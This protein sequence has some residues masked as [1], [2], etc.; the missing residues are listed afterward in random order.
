MK[1]HALKIVCISALLAAT[2]ILLSASL[3]QVPSGTWAAVGSMNSARAGASTV[4]LQDGRILITGGSD[5]NGPSSAAEFFGANGSFSAAASMNV[6]RSGHISVV[7]QD[8][9]VLVA[10]GTTSGGGVTNSAEMFD[11]TANSWTNVTGGMMEARSGETATLLSDGRVLIAGGSGSGASISMTAELFDT[12]SQSF[13][14]AGVLSSA[15]FNHAAALLLDGRVLIVG[16]SDGSKALATSDIFD[17]VASTI[18][19]GPKLATARQALSA[20]TL[21]DGRVLIA[22]GNNVVVNPD[23][24]SS[25]V[26]L[27]SAEILDAGATAFSNAASALV[28]ARSGQQAFLLPHNNSVLIVG[29][30]SNGTT[31]A[32]AE[33][34]IP[35][36]N[37]QAGIFQ[38]TGSMATPRSGAT[39]AALQQDGLLLVAGGKDAGGTPLSSSELYGF[40]TVK[41]DAADYPPGTTVNITGSGW[42]P[43]EAVTLTL[44]E[45]PLIDT[46]G[47][48]TVT[49]DANGN[50]SDSSFVTDAHDLNVKF[51]LTAV[52]LVSQ[53]QTIFTDATHIGSITVGAQTGSLTYGSASSATYTVTVTGSG[54][55][56]VTATL[57]IT[58]LPAGA[59][60]TFSPASVTVN[61]SS[62][63]STLTITT[64]TSAQAAATTF[65]VTNTDNSVTGTGTLTIGKRPITVTA[66]TNSKQYDG[67]TAAAATPTI[68]SGTPAAGDTA[69]FTEAYST[70][71]V[72]TGNKTLI[73]S[74]SVNDGHGGV[75]YTVIFVNNT[76]GTIS[77][78]PLTVTAT[79]NSKTYDGTT[80]AA[81]TPSITSGTIQTGGN[82]R[83][84]E[85]RQRKDV[86]A[87]RHRHRRKRRRELHLYLRPQ[88]QRYDLGPGDHGD[89]G[90]QQQT[91]RWNDQFLGGAH[92]HQRQP[93]LG[94]LGNVD[95][96]LRQQERRDDPRHDAGGHGQ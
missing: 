85:C 6:Q 12:A 13:A 39:G 95:R 63:N 72:G 50:I 34:Y 71:N 57:G 41:T 65:T 94:R 45:S 59:S 76:V 83:H 47:P 86:D 26:D 60:G 80:S 96:N 2:G 16:G 30:T 44:V 35:W 68:T 53:A 81:A 11:P 74:G 10:G 32:S 8:G 29:G 67:T 56:G 27:A 70:K 17:P 28:T 93:G 77:A 38:A 46:H 14:L 23:G 18:S 88:R 20:T 66:A 82:L 37:S 24:T 1:K 79:A 19:A 43:G 73:P 5:A 40:A 62:A 25:T 69:N 87:Q 42:Q 78:R 64:S 49:A 4:L 54:A 52:G 58:G 61:N 48:Y 31:I 89:S 9:R 92:D 7:L 75:N 91:L 33:L 21:L 90:S 84:Q 51:T 22:G 55:G 15:R 36:S 3:P